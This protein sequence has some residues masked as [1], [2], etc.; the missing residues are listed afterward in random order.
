MAKKRI[1]ILGA[2]LAGLSAAWHLQK[3]GRECVVFE[4]EPEVGGLC[5][6]KNINGFI[7]DYDAHLLHFKSRSIF[8]LVKALLGNNLIEHQRS[9][10]V[11]SSGQ[12]SPY[13]FQ[14]NIYNLPLSVIKE[15]LAGI[16]EAS[17]DSHVKNR[18]NTNFLEWINKNFGKGIAK[19]FMVPYNTKFWTIPPQNLTCEW[20]NGFVPA[21]SKNQII[22]GIFE[23]NK[24]QFGY[25]ARFW[26]PKKGGINQLPLALASEIKNVYN[27]CLVTEID[28]Y[29]KKIKLSSGEREKFDY[30]VSTAPLP[31]MSRIIKP[32]PSHLKLLFSKLSWNSVFNL[33]LGIERSD[34]LKR[35]WVYF[36]EKEFCFFRVGFS[37]NFSASLV[38]AGKSSIYVEVSYSK[39]KPLDKKNIIGRIKK[40]LNNAGIL[41]SSDKVCARDINDIK[42]GYPIYDNNYKIARGGIIDY[43]NRK[44]VIACGRYGSWRYMSMTDVM[45]DGERAAHS[46]FKNA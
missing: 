28:L 40:G 7:F 34:K 10:W 41:N 6:S 17:L 18:Q 45:L 27:S 35:H 15:C 37:H 11:Y 2:G 25:N 46:I 1:I 31:E 3:K 13:P 24:R 33:N 32:L 20:L 5:R 8:N 23:K 19:H 16:T 42:Y 26:Y 44:N 43:F 38:P 12:Y 22:E 14:A 4:K 36:A 29:K 30:L 9:A 39:H 21:P